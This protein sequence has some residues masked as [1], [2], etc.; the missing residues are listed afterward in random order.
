[1]PSVAETPEEV[2]KLLSGKRVLHVKGFGAGLGAPPE[3]QRDVQ[4]RQDEAAFAAISRF[5][6][7]YLVVDGDP[8][9]D[10]YQRYVKAYADRQAGAGLAVPGLVWVKNVKG[11][12]P[13]P[14]E[15]DKH[16]KKA[17]E[18]ADQGLQVVVSWLP[19]AS[20]SEGV[21]R[22]FG[23]G[24]WEQLQGQRF[25][26]RGALRLLPPGEPEG[27]EW[28]RGLRGSAPGRELCQAIEAVESRPEQQGFETCSFENAA[29]GNAIYQHLRGGGHQPAAQGAV[30]FGGGES[31]LLEFATLYLLP[32]SG[33]DADQAALFPF[34]RGRP[35]DPLLPAHE[36]R[37]FTALGSMAAAD[38]PVTVREAAGE[39]PADSVLTAPAPPG[40]SPIEA[41][42]PRRPPRLAAWA[43]PWLQDCDTPAP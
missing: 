29:K 9:K 35:S 14:E 13:T 30:S 22:L 17:R 8:W 23:A 12:S 20:I 31:V 34:G 21:D 16:L 25:D 7:D 43:G 41:V 24:S 1:E 33:F 39:L 28:L 27:P 36:G 26:F 5:R 18:W 4:E 38:E 3:G 19:E 10:G 37:A 42:P 6:P 15:R 11:S 2:W 32:G 40:R